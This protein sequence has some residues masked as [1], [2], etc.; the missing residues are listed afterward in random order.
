M[1]KKNFL[2]IQQIKNHLLVITDIEFFRVDPGE[3]I[4]RAFRFYTVDA[5][6]TVQH[7][8]SHIPLDFE[9]TTIVNQIVNAL[10]PTQRSLNRALAGHIGTHPHGCKHVDPFYIVFSNTLVPADY[11]PAGTETCHPVIFRQT[12]QRHTEHFISQG[13]NAGMLMTVVE[14]FVIDLIRENNQAVFFGYI[15]NL[16]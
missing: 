2:F 16:L 10:I 1:D 5:G 4:H 14:N 12:S 13:S 6:N 9:A 11:Q 7:I 8:C 3:A 15:D